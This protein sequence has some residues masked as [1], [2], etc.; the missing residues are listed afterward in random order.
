MDDDGL[1]RAVRRPAQIFG[2]E[3]DEQLAKRLIASVR[4]RED[5]LPLLQHGLMLMWEDARRRAPPGGRATLDGRIVDEAGSLAQ[6]LSSHADA[7]MASAAP[8]EGRQWIVEAM[9]RA[10]TDVNSEGS[11]IRRPLTF[12]KLCAVTGATP[13][14]LRPILDAFRASGV[15]FLTPYELEPIDERTPIDISHEAL[16]RWWSKIDDRP[17]G[18]LQKEIREG[19][20]WRALLFQAENFLSDRTNVLSAPAT[21]LAERRLEGRN[22]AWA[23]R[24]GDGWPKVEELVGASREHWKQRADEAEEEER[25]KR[26]EQERRVRD[27][28]LIADEQKKAAIAHRRTAQVALNALVIALLRGGGGLAIH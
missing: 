7:V 19:L 12:H 9:F 25:Q 13:E 23:D 28:E 24:Y 8:D 5:E 20:G 1:M 17:N 21:E 4:G 18:W 22:E 11:A 10:L 6:L 27:A 2:G 14:E 3:I 26:E 16:I 15:S